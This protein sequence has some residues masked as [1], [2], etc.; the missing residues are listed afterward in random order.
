[1]VL[2]DQLITTLT[3]EELIPAMCCIAPE[4]PIAIY[5]WLQLVFQ[6]VRYCG[7]HP[8]SDTGLNKQLLH[9]EH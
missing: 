3:F 6:R 7:R 4:I 1:M 8:K 5:N 2:L 9:Q